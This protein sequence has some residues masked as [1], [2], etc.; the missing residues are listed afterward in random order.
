[1]KEKTLT[2][3]NNDSLEFQQNLAD[4]IRPSYE[5]QHPVIIRGLNRHT[6]AF[7]EWH[8]LEYLRQKVGVDTSCEVEIGSMYS[9][10]EVQKSIIEFGQYCDYVLLASGENS[11]DS[12]DAHENIM[13]TVYLAQNE[14]FRSLRKD[15]DVPQFCQDRSLEVGNGSLDFQMLWF[16]PA[17]CVSPLH[18]DPLDNLF[19]QFS[20]VKQFI[21]YPQNLDDDN[22]C[23][24]PGGGGQMNTSSIG[25]IEQVDLSTFPRFREAPQP[26]FASVTPGDALYIPKKWW[27]HVRSLERSV[28]VNIFWK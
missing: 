7:R 25:D 16:G 26:L 24:Y 22:A 11:S 14:V 20:G 17:G 15:Y 12:S 9:D 18:F 1:M 21:L 2:L 5:M 19:L 28:S 4:M 23:F 8:D 3:T 10:S 13:P 6:K 27:H